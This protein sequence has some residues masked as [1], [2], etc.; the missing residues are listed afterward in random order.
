MQSLCLL[1]LGLTG[2]GVSARQLPHI[3]LPEEL[4]VQNATHRRGRIKKDET[5]LADI[6]MLQDYLAD[7]PGFLAR[8]LEAHSGALAVGIADDNPTHVETHSDALAVGIADDNPHVAPLT[9]GRP[10]RAVVQRELLTDNVRFWVALASLGVGVAAL[11]FSGRRREECEM[12]AEPAGPSLCVLQGV[13]ATLALLLAVETYK[14]PEPWLRG[15]LLLAD[16]VVHA[17]LLIRGVL[18]FVEGKHTVAAQQFRKRLVVWSVWLDTRAH[19]SFVTAAVGWCST[20]IAMVLFVMVSMGG[21]SV[22]PWA[23]WVNH[24]VLG[25]TALAVSCG[26]RE[27]HEAQSPALFLLANVVAGLAHRGPI[28]GA[29]AADIA[30]VVIPLL[31]LLDAIRGWYRLKER[32]SSDDPAKATY[33]CGGDS[34]LL[35]RQVLCT[36]NGN[37]DTSDFERHLM[38]ERRVCY[39]YA[40]QDLISCEAATSHSEIKD[41]YLVWRALFANDRAPLR[42]NLPQEDPDKE[43]SL[44]P[45]AS[46]HRAKQAL[47]GTLRASYARFL[48]RK[49]RA[50]SAGSS[51]RSFLTAMRVPGCSGPDWPLTVV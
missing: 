33:H 16:A 19:M 23:W 42:V 20:S 7:R 36:L 28:S 1:Q 38:E 39:F 34:R 8:P 47:L 26:Q 12:A 30:L 24:A 18:S 4:R 51:P 9:T 6:S 14:H 21:H 45:Q 41:K 46:V 10:T 2:T 27:S 5:I 3:E 48:I 31:Q 37:Q 15:L 29:P 40:F 32:L 44:C 13:A 50:L 17:A 11:A 49:R 35:D 25:L 43:N 22:Y